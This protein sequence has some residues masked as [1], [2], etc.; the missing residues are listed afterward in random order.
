M[1]DN[2]CASRSY[3]IKEFPTE[4]LQAKHDFFIINLSYFL[5]IYKRFNWFESQLNIKSGKVLE[6]IL[7]LKK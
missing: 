1:R 6:R 4:S 3:T 7:N 2:S 5:Q